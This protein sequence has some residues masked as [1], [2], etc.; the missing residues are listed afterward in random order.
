MNGRMEDP[1]E[2]IGRVFSWE[3]NGWQTQD[4]M[5]DGQEVLNEPTGY[6]ECQENDDEAYR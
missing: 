4:T 3:N 1:K 2:I 5:G 6:Q